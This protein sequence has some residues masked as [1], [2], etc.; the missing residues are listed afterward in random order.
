V[1]T[2]LMTPYAAHNVVSPQAGLLGPVRRYLGLC[3]A[4]A[5]DVDA[6]REHFAQARE[7]SRRADAAPILAM[8]ALDE[9]TML[10]ANGD[11]GRGHTLA[12]E[13][14]ERALA[15]GLEPLAARAAAL[16]EQVASTTSAAPSR[17]DTVDP[18]TAS[19]TR[20]GEV[21]TA[22][23]SGRV[24][25]LRDAKGL[26]HL[27]RL[28]SHPG[29]EFHAL[30]LVAGETAVPSTAAVGASREDDLQVSTGG[31]AGPALDSAAKSAYRARI[32][33]LREELDEAESF[34]D[35]ERADRAREE[36]EFIGRELAGAVGLGG[37]DRK[38]GSDA[39]RARV[40]VTRAIRSVIK[41]AAD[42]DAALGH[43]WDATVRTGTFCVHEPDPRAPVRWEVDA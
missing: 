7:T 22:N 6:A 13:A 30:D 37:R 34:N 12:L 25:R 32:A 18:A 3:A 23:F 16:L 27:A 31:D 1:I 2:E 8:L 33:E 4:T 20:E 21:W 41:R 40:N 11:A 19:L 15:L 26:H 42:E 24:V 14:A 43:E 9:A 10:F 35:P 38:Q 36:L 29:V 39:E 17:V 5:G 28:L